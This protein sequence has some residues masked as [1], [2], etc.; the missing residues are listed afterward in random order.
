MNKW[1]SNFCALLLYVLIQPSSDMVAECLEYPQNWK[2]KLKIRFFIESIFPPWLSWLERF[3]T[4][5]NPNPHPQQS[6]D[7]GETTHLHDDWRNIIHKRGD[8]RRDTNS[9]KI[10]I[11]KLFI[12]PS[13]AR[14]STLSI[15]PPLFFACSSPQWQTTWKTEHEDEENGGDGKIHLTESFLY[16]CY[17][18]K[19]TMCKWTSDLRIKKTKF[20]FCE[21]YYTSF[22][23][24]S[25]E[26]RNLRLIFYVV[27][28][29]QRR[30]K[31]KS[32]KTS[33]SCA[34]GKLC[35]LLTIIKFNQFASSLNFYELFLQSF[36]RSS[37]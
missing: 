3:H 27:D 25:A 20:L 15:Y 9:G 13:S 34:L 31:R 1:N 33:L 21:L 10:F 37:S 18:I 26:R 30:K 19:H 4:A 24:L 5:N 32:D 36:S 11:G 35:E 29:Q 2:L 28:P 23:M 14:F 7:Q 22:L 12:L 6:T 16:C 8:W 17:T